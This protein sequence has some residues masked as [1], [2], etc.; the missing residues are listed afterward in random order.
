M[1]FLLILVAATAAFSA[2]AQVRLLIC[3][4]KIGTQ[5]ITILDDSFKVGLYQGR[6]DVAAG[7][8]GN[9]FPSV[10]FNREEIR[11]TERNDNCQMVLSSPGKGT[12]TLTASCNGE[13][14][15]KVTALDL[16]TLSLTSASVD[17][18]CRLEDYGRPERSQRPQRNE[19]PQRERTDACS[20]PPGSSLDP[21]YPRRI[22]S[23]YDPYCDDE[24]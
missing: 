9:K 10:V 23:S 20:N 24:E 3:E 8:S 12:L 11:Y 6:V 16:K 17:V 18:T 19:R 1:K 22:G 2:T 21:D 4:G 13:G 14:P 5:D 15:A 7:P